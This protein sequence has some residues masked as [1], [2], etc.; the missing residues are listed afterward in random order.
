MGKSVK[1]RIKSELNELNGKIVKLDEFIKK[2]DFKKLNKENQKLLK[3]QKNV[4]EKY[5]DILIKR[6]ELN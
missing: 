3:E 2:A 5:A 1:A 4:M 6:I